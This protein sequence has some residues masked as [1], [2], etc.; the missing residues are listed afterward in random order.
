MNH[1]SQLA[2]QAQSTIRYSIVVNLILSIVK[3]AAGILGNSFA[4]IADAAESWVD[5]ASSFLVWLGLR[6]AALPP[7]KNHP[8]G[9]GKA[10]PLSAMF[11][12]VLMF[13][14]ACFIV[15]EA[16]QHIMTPHDS[17][18]SWT[19]IVVIGVLITKEILY[20]F[21]KLNAKKF[22][23]NALAA[24]ATHQRTDSITS[25]AALVG[26]VISLVAGD[27]YAAAD[28]WASLLAAYFI[29]QQAFKVGKTAISELMDEAQPE[30]IV[31]EIRDTAMQV[32]GVIR[33][34]ACFVR[35]M[36]FEWF[37]DIHIGLNG[38]QSVYEGHAIAHVVVDKIKE[39]FPQVYDV[40]THIEP[41]E[42]NDPIS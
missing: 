3:F 11:V 42:D 30:E 7:D 4:L 23:S 35:K 19:I 8:Y 29:L 31:N 33:I 26:I 16:I 18:H 5:F 1:S 41:H 36:G 34:N 9:H 6:T 28:D 13:S 37:V 20:R 22:K 14:V 25:L 21:M 2:T 24:E 38:N 17:P 15:Y 27:G 39:Q 12:A 40:L 10:E 32:D